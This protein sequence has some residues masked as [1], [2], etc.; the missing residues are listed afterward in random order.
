MQQQQQLD[1]RHRDH[2]ICAPAA[3]PTSVVHVGLKVSVL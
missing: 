1:C 3:V 2:R